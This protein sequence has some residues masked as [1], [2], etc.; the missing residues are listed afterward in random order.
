MR[1]FGILNEN[2]TIKIEICNLHMACHN[3]LK[4]NI[5]VR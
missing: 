1:R 4:K 5:I 2:R 3:E